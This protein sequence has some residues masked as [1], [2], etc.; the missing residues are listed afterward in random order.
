VLREV[1]MRVL[2]ITLLL[3]AGLLAAAC[4]NDDDGDTGNIDPGNGAANGD[5]TNGSNG[6][7]NGGDEPAPTN[8]PRPLPTPT[9]VRDDAVI[10]VVAAG[11][12]LHEPTR[13]EFQDFEQT[14]ITVGGAD[15]TGVSIATLA[16]ETGAPDAAFVT[17][18]GLR[19]GGERQAIWR[20]AMAEVGEDSVLVIGPA[21]HLQLASASIPEDQWIESIGSIDFS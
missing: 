11:G 7:N 4:G 19:P 2:L 16:A 17:I 3:A 15:Y 5:D 21:G 14:T 8:T 18:E 12:E 20:F 6:D 1:F 13:R 10:V 9:P